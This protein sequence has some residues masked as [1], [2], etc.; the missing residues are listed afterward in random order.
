MTDPTVLPLEDLPI[1]AHLV[2][3]PCPE[4]LAQSYLRCLALAEGHML[5]R[6]ALTRKPLPTEPYP[7]YLDLR[8]AINRIQLWC[9]EADWHPRSRLESAACV[10]DWATDTSI[11]SAT[12]DR[13]ERLDH[14]VDMHDMYQMERFADYIS[15][16]DSRLL[17]RL[18]PETELEAMH[19]QDSGEMHPDAETGYL[20]VGIAQQVSAISP[21][22]DFYSKENEVLSTCHRKARGRLE[23]VGSGERIRRDLAAEAARYEDIFEG[24]GLFRRR[25]EYQRAVV[26]VLDDILPIGGHGDLLPSAVLF[27]E[28]LGWL[29]IMATV[30]DGD[31][32]SVGR[33]RG[34]HNLA[35]ARREMEVLERTRLE[36]EAT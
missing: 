6:V 2:F 35:L 14:L 12:G 23:H 15:E 17:R 31:S 13:V 8:K 27:T 18:D 9:G 36:M 11:E 26:G 29:R 33:R 4:S 20:I 24:R 10:G 16:A 34:R 5:D 30:G 32:S 3:E 25:G 19:Q 28:Y 1:Q 22:L 7:F 21:V